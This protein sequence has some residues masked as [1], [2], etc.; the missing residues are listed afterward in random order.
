MR[1]ALMIVVTL[2]AGTIA[3]AAESR[4]EQ[5][6]VA[7]APDGTVVINN[8]AGSIDVQAWDQEQVAATA[9]LEGP[10]LGL[11]VSSES[12]RTKVSITGYGEHSMGFG[13][14]GEAQLSVRVP[15]MSRIELSGVSADMTT[16]GL[17]GAQRL[18]SV[19]G[20]IR[21]D[22]STGDMDAR[23]VSGN[24][25]LHGNGQ[26]SHVTMSSVSGDMSL[27]NGAGD[28][29]ASTVSGSLVAALNAAH[30]VSA[31]TT[32][33]DIS[34][35]GNLAPGA[36]LEGNSITGRV[37]IQERT[38][39]GFSYDLESFNGHI[40]DCFGQ[41]PQRTGKYGPRSELSGTRGVGDA[42]IHIK[43]LSGEVSLCDH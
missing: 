4:T 24:I 12:G 1:A 36:S 39:A 5:Q 41:E 32:S 13:A 21:A 18:Q 37:Q 10:A 11:R 25:E 6:Q 7:A 33:G 29:Q 16:R 22:L 34:L 19:S 2:L 42:K 26:P 28:L 20:T 38:P 15:K 23:T 3:L 27:T 9:Q 8:V 31:H 40:E 35:S 17:L 30:T 43:T 14:H